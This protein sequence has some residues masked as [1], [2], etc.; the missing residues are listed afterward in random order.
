MVKVT[1][2]RAGLYVTPCGYEIEN[3]YAGEWWV[4]YPGERMADDIYPTLKEALQE[5][6]D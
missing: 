4:T 2:I 5:I 6:G 3:R 1:R